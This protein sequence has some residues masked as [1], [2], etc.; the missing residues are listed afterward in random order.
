MANIL[1]VDDESSARSTM[2][3]LLRK[4]GHQV[5]EADGVAAAIDALDLEA[6]DLVLTDLRMPDGGGLDVLRAARTRR[7]DASVIL[8][9]AYA[10]WDSAKEAMRLGAIDYFE[11]GHAPEDLL[12]QIEAALAA[13][14]WTVP[15]R[16][17][18]E[19]PGFLTSDDARR[20][21][22]T[23]LTVLFADLRGSLELV[24]GQSLE[25][26]RVVLD[27]V[28]ERMMDAVHHHGGT[29]NQVMGDG[30]M[31][32]FGATETTDHAHQACDAAV[33]MQ[34][35]IARYSATLGRDREIQI[36]VGIASGEVILR[37]VGS[38]LRRDYSAVGLTT[39][40][41]ARLEQAARPGTIFMT[42]ATQRL[43]GGAVRAVPRGRTAIKG[44]P[45]GVETYELLGRVSEGALPANG[46]EDEGVVT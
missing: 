6:F 2:A 28:L 17:G 22:R 12:Q 41:A 38:D 43:V 14:P 8:L 35:A 29:V 23:L 4:R 25:S 33:A 24:A 27:A 45:D 46:R 9:T 26:A 40:V 21:R 20:G 16:E 10:G 18:L 37:S 44:L 31:A 34:T 13:P 30:I 7:S 32:L 36:R 19:P 15:L 11:K 1:L 5:R 3:L 39:H 42:A